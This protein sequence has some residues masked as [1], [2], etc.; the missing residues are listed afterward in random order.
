MRRKQPKYIDPDRFREKKAIQAQVQPIVRRDRN[1]F[2]DNMT[3]PIPDDIEWTLRYGKPTQED[4]MFSASIVSAYRGLVMKNK[5]ERDR[6]IR[7]LKPH[8]V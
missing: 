2:F 8:F 3:W 4:I 6:V 7:V 1:L 5:K